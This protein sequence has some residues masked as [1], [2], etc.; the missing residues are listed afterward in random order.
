MIS[1]AARAA[2][3]SKATELS[4]VVACDAIQATQIISFNCL[5]TEGIRLDY[6]DASQFLP[7]V[8]SGKPVEE[9]LPASPPSVLVLSRFGGVLGPT[10]I[11]WARRHAVPVIF[12]IDDDLLDVPTSLGPAKYAHYRDPNRL[13]VLRESMDSADLV[14]ASTGPLA[15]RLVEHGISSPIVA[16]DLYCSVDPATI[17]PPVPA[18]LPV[19]G[20]MGSSGH[21][22]D[23]AL[24]L[25]VI[26]DL[27]ESRPNLSFELFGTIPMPYE[28]SRFGPRVLH[29]P[30]FTDYGDFLTRMKILGW[31]IGLAPLED[32][33]FNRCK[34]D[35]KWVEYTQAGC[36]VVASDL[37][38]YAR[39]CAQGAGFLAGPPDEWLAKVKL[40]LDSSEIRTSIVA[41]AQQK[42]ATSYTDDMLRQQVMAILNRLLAR[43]P[44][45]TCN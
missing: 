32:N 19:I 4:V 6:W 38:V 17:F 33:N 15:A 31:W 11:R 5:R 3:N 35:T 28:L 1:E 18:T 42:L 21:A 45:G 41:R 23:L 44:R 25:P 24:V 20:Y 26:I 29:H 16:G 39:A 12:H 37:P 30:G 27:L 13:A 14:Y 34:A 40:L 22:A 2:G 10:L 36:A 43:K 7:L 8:K 9:Y